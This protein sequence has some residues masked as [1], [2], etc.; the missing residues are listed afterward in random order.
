MANPTNGASPESVPQNAY[1]ELSGITKDYGAIRALDDVHFWV[2]PAEIVGLVGDNGAGKSTLIKIISGVLQPTQG[3]IRVEGKIIRFESSKIA[4]DHGI[5]TIYQ[6][7]NLIDVMDITRNIFCGREETNAL[8]FLKI[9]NMKEK[10][11]SVLEK[12]ITIEGIR[13]PNQRVGHLSGGQKQA[14]SIARAMFFKKRVLLLDE[15]TS[16]LSVRETQA[17]LDHIVHLRSEGMSV[18]LVTHNIYH[19]HQVADRFVLLSHGK[20]IMDT[21]KKDTSTEEL[22][23]IIVAH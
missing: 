14:V 12:E 21:L 11:M 8:G 2:N 13:S 22:T 10:A 23:K 1:I 19:A 18:V 20:K 5:E 9:R 16:A 6:D 7:M 3:T 17:F 4:M 15:P